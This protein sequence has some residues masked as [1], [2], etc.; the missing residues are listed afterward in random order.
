MRNFDSK[1][2]RIPNLNLGGYSESL[3]FRGFP[4]S[5]SPYRIYRKVAIIAKTGDLSTM[6]PLGTEMTYVVRFLLFGCEKLRTRRYVDSSYLSHGDVYIYNRCV[7]PLLNSSRQAP[8]IS[9]CSI[10]AVSLQWNLL[11]SLKANAETET[12]SARNG[13]MG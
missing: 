1:D 5:V 12:S 8:I 4:G 13:P 2:R 7:S 10:G 3:A 9:L 6:L 11:S